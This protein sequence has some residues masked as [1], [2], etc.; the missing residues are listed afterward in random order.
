MKA[1]R[2][3]DYE[4]LQPHQVGRAI[5][6]ALIATS[7]ICLT[8]LFACVTPFAAL[9]ALAALKLSRSD[10]FAVVGLVW[11]ANQ[12][13]GFGILGYPW[14]WDSAAWG[15]AIGAS[16]GFSAVAARGLCISRPAPLAVSLPFVAA[17]AS[18]EL[19]L[20]AAGYLLPVSEGAFSA[21]V[22]AHVFLINVVALCGLMSVYRLAILVADLLRHD[23]AISDPGSSLR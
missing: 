3:F 22:V 20:Y 23:A 17:F 11:L 2:D 18:F 10:M 8:P 13:I 12:A 21:S 9:A 7:G 6:I 14:T 15:F 5:W 1:T 19:G 4:V 16:A